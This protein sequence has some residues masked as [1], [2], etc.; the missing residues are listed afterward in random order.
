MFWPASRSLRAARKKSLPSWVMPPTKCVL[1]WVSHSLQ[2][3][4]S[5][6]LLNKPL[7][8]HSTRSRLTALPTTSRT[9]ALISQPFLYTSRRL[10]KTL[11]LRLLTPM[12]QAYANSGQ[13]DLAVKSINS[14]F[15]LRQRASEL[16]R[17]YIDTRYYEL[18]T[19]DVDKR[20]EVLQLWKR[21]YPRDSVPPNDLAAEYT[22]MGKYDQALA[23]AQD[24]VRLAPNDHTG[25]ELLGIS[26]LGLNRFD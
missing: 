13:D 26:Y 9:A 19:G 14:A 17:F 6:S 16:E 11:N 4:N 12:G 7:R 20:I 24:E 25:Y 22:D 23:E 15:D 1:N 21:M 2:Y 3:S 10:Q 5:M 8:H 18:V